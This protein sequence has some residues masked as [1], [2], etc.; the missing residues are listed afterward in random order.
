M[1]R[2]ASENLKSGDGSSMFSRSPSE[3]NGGGADSPMD[4]YIQDEGVSEC[5]NDDSFVSDYGTPIDRYGHFVEMDPELEARL[6]G[7]GSDSDSNLDDFAV[8]ISC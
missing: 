2:Y 8:A 6:D 5:W 3:S 1:R 4:A 7:T